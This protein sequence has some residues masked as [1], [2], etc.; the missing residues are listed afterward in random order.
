MQGEGWPFP[1]FIHLLLF[2]TTSHENG[3]PYVLYS[4]SFVS[5]HLLRGGAHVVGPSSSFWGR[6]APQVEGGWVPLLWYIWSLLYCLSS[7]TKR[8]G[9][10]VYMGVLVS[11]NVSSAPSQSRM[12]IQALSQSV[13]YEY[14]IIPFGLTNAPAVFQALVKD[15]LRDFLNCFAFIYLGDILIFSQN[16]CDHVSHVH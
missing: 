15:V 16:M 7:L 1:S 12:Q 6:G 5:S 2:T 14:L 9:S 8:H 3:R 4:P 11:Q 13:F 10:P